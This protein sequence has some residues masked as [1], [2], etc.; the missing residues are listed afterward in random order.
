MRRLVVTFVFLVFTIA[1]VTSYCDASDLQQHLRDH[2]QGKTFL[3]RGFYSGD[4]LHYDSSG[5]LKGTAIPGDWTTDGVIRV[6]SI[7]ASSNR[8]EMKC[9]RMLVT[10]GGIFKLVPAE[11]R[12]GLETT[13][14]LVAI[15]ADLAG[16]SSSSAEADAVFSKI[17][18]VNGDSLADLVPT[19]WHSCI[20]DG[21]AG[22][23]HNCTF[24]TE[25]LAVPGVAFFKEQGNPLTDSSSV[26]LASVGA[27]SPDR[28][29][30]TYRVGV[31]VKPPRVIFSPEPSFSEE[32]RV[33]RYQG[34]VTL[35]LVVDKEGLPQ[36][37]QILSPLGAGLD[38]QAV[39]TVETWR[40]Q[41]ATREGQPVNVEIAVEV[42]FHLY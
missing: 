24:S 35:A 11:R 41:P 17:L 1:C 19:Y 14:A 23:S 39:H 38:A 8:I 20:S 12:R 32:A 21:L 27:G 36:R 16:D 33:V 28:Q 31:G 25:L 4:Q 29:P 7:H 42:D 22:K 6:D 26:A 3:I 18:L 10:A 2:Y 30:V 40:F 13:P 15:D 37:V 34:I 5:K 9:K